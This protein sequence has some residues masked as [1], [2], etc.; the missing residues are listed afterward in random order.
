MANPQTEFDNTMNV[1]RKFDFQHVYADIRTER[2]K[3]SSQQEFLIKAQLNLDDLKYENIIIIFQDENA[4]YS[5]ERMITYN[6]PTNIDTSFYF[7]SNPR[8]NIEV[9]DDH[10]ITVFIRD[11]YTSGQL[12][13][14]LSGNDTNRTIEGNVNKCFQ[15]GTI[16][17][18][19]ANQQLSFIA[20]SNSIE[21][22]IYYQYENQVWLIH[23]NAAQ[24]SFIL[25]HLIDNNVFYISLSFH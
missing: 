14:Q 10:E 5:L 18:V 20:N 9:T 21:Y 25:Y 6:H 4:R 8:I 22:A 12:I 17:T 7:G 3:Y 1:V 23:T 16:S 15:R 2:G 19:Y 11:S 13:L 24:P